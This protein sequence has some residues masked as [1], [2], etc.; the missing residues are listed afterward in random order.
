MRLSFAV[1]AIIPAALAA[2]GAT[3]ASGAEPAGG[4]KGNMVMRAVLDEGTPQVEVE[5]EGFVLRTSSLRVMD[6]VRAVE[7][8]RAVKVDD[9][10]GGISL[11]IQSVGKT[12][13]PVG[14]FR[15]RADVIEYDGSRYRF[16][17]RDGRRVRMWGGLSGVTAGIFGG[18]TRSEDVFTEAARI[19]IA[20]QRR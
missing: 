2:I 9:P 19:E 4:A 3:A 10:G 13:L 14:P 17:G 5:R 11:E 6:G 20:P 1:A 15:A 8:V 18:G 7:E 12:S 16:L